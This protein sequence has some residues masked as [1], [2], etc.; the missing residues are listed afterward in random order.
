MK[1][2][3][4]D[5]F[6]IFVDGFMICAE[7]WAEL[8][9]EEYLAYRKCLKKIKFS[10]AAMA[11]PAS[12]HTWVLVIEESW[13]PVQPDS[14]LPQGMVEVMSAM[15]LPND[16]QTRKFI[17]NLAFSAESA[18]E[19]GEWKLQSIEAQ[20]KGGQQLAPQGDS[21]VQEA[22]ALREDVLGQYK[23]A[24]AYSVGEGLTQNDALA[25]YW[26]DKA[27]RQGPSKWQDDVEDMFGNGSAA[28]CNLADMYENGVGVAQNYELALYWYKQAAAQENPVAYYSLGVMYKNGSGVAKDM[29]QAAA[30]FRQAAAQSYEPADLE[31]AQMG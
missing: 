19:H 25:F 2:S 31:L 27:A 17:W 3:P 30:Y 10:P 5:S 22:L 16:M 18:T 12:P 20:E 24:Y 23:I 26:Y 11:T 28:K 4:A 13:E 7:L 1:I 15:A 6:G 9:D 21:W 29:A 8:H 14:S